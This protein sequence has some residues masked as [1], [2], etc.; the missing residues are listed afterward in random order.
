MF[1]YSYR[2]RGGFIRQNPDGR[3][4]VIFDIWSY[5]FYRSSGFL[6][7]QLFDHLFCHPVFY[8]FG[9]SDLVYRTS[10]EIFDFCTEAVHVSEC[11][12]LQLKVD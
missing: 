12:A 11:T 7:I 4:I 9:P 8:L 5:E 6:F 3:I 1:N 2:Y 10:S